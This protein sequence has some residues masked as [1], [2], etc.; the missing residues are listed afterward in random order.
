M[1]SP[2]MSLQWSL[3]PEISGAFITGGNA[4]SGHPVVMRFLIA[5]IVIMKR[6]THWTLIPF[7]GTTFRDMK[8]KWSYAPNVALSKMSN[9]IALAVEFAWGSTFARN[10]NSS[11]MMFQRTNTT[12]M[13]VESAELEARRISSTAT[14]VSFTVMDCRVLLFKCDSGFPSLCGKSNAPQLSSLLRVPIRH[15]ER[16]NRLTMWSYDTFGM[17]ER[18]GATL[19]VRTLYSCPVCSKSIC[20]MS[21]VWEK[22]DR[23]I[24][25]TPMPQLYQN[26]LVRILCNDCGETSVVHFHVVAHKCQKCK[27]YNTR[28]IQGGSTSSCPSRIG[29]VTAD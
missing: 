28:Q 1:G 16:S 11:M 19:Q 7:V 29:E 3:N 2:K 25:S 12:V 15:D 14:S 6:R 8:L 26:K 21:D 24:A 17:C 9:K 5:G 22:L 4:K 20:D 18:N 23:E 10:A 13:D 27:S